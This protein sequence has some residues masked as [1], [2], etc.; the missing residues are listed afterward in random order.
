MLTNSDF[1]ADFYR[2]D[3][4]QIDRSRISLTGGSMGADA[5][6]QIAAHHPEV[7]SCVTGIVP[8]HI[9]CPIA[10]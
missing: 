8:Y 1:S 7:F 2:A 5:A 3:A 9:Q 6:I 10:K 4:H